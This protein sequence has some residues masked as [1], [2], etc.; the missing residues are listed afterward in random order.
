MNLEHDASGIAQSGNGSTTGGS[1]SGSD[2]GICTRDVAGPV[3]VTGL[4]YE[5]CRR[6]ANRRTEADPAHTQSI[7]LAIEAKCSAATAKANNEA[8][9]DEPELN[10]PG[11]RFCR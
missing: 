8:C 10:A 6:D 4:A 5:I 9:P 7:Q 3:K 11:C 1:Q 2:G